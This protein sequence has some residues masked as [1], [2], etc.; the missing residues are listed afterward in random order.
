MKSNK[1]VRVPLMRDVPFEIYSEWKRLYT[2]GDLLAI[3]QKTG[4]HRHTIAKALNTGKATPTMIQ[5]ITSFYADKKMKDGYEDTLFV[6]K[7]KD[8][9]HLA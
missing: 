3:S 4:R 8:Q 5:E 6:R 9:L 7:L 1:K 2:F